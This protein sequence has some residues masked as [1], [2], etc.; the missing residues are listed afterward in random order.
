MLLILNLV[1]NWVKNQ[2]RKFIIGTGL[3]D[4]SL[5]G[6]SIR[7]DEDG[8]LIVIASNETIGMFKYWDSWYEDRQT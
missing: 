7:I 2:M 4:I 8:V 1:L 5:E 3:V 6:E